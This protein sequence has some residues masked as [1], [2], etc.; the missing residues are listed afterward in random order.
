MTRRIIQIYRGTTAQNDAFTGEAGELTMDTT[1]NEL[2]IHDGSTAGG[3]KIGRGYHP[4]LFAHQ[5]SDHI[6]NDTSWLR[7][8]TFS[9]QDGGAY[10]A[11]YNHLVDDID[12]KPLTSETIGSTTVQFYLADDGHKICPASEES[13][14]SAIFTATGVAWYYILDTANTQFKLPRSKHE[15]YGDRAVVGN[16]KPLGLADTVGMGG[17]IYLFSVGSSGGSTWNYTGNSFTTRTLNIGDSL[18]VSGDV[19]PVQDK[20]LGLSTV[21]SKSG[22][23]S[24]AVEDTGQYKYLYFYVGS[25][26]QTALENT[27][28]LN[29]SLFNGKVDLDAANL[30]AA[31]KS[32]VAEL[33]MPSDK[34]DNLTMGANGTQ[35]TAPAN[36][37]FT[38]HK[39]ANGANQWC[40]MF[41]TSGL[42]VVQ[43]TP[44]NG[45][46]CQGVMPARKGDVCTI[47]YTA[48]GAANKFLFV[49]AEGDK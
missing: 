43:W 5:W 2:R 16:G 10:E 15:H 8:D 9:W 24:P 26:T 45:G 7:G 28:G 30:S 19:D 4:E 32:L 46:G 49:Y 47:G 22:I 17:N 42:D 29:A 38:W 41:S 37:Y 36:G 1:T 6:I 23:V 11:A 34:Y 13:N 25:F 35:Y 39:T 21:D 27:A 20:A 18:P 44:I 48:G 33:G 31:G 40:G 3:H 14:V 12:G